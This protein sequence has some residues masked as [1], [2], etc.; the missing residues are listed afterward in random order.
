[1]RSSRKVSKTNNGVS[2]YVA[3][4]MIASMAF[5]LCLTINYRAFTEMSR[6]AEENQNLSWQIKN[7]TTENLA[8]QDEIHNLRTDPAAIKREA[9]RLGLTGRANDVPVTANR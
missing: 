3:L 9:E 2:G 1:M 8:L 6:E 5:M 4:A 7:L